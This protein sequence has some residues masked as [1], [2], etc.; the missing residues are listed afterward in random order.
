MAMPAKPLPRKLDV[1]RLEFT[2]L[3][4]E[5]WKDFAKL[6]GSNGACGGCWCMAWRLARAEFNAG[7]GEPNRKAMRK[8]VDSG[9]MPG[10]L[11]YYEGEPIGWC[12]I[13]PREVYPALE[14]S[15]VL[16]PI[17]ERPVWSVSCFFVAKPFRVQGVSVELLKA[18]VRFAASRG[19]T[20]VEGYPQDLGG[21]KLPAPFVWTGLAG[22]F[23]AAGFQEAARR[24]RTRP[25][26]RE[27]VTS[28]P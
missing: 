21:S 28:R 4:K 26:M 19:A 23:R 14:R 16:K 6:F 8:I 3:T 12:A 25:I 18:A 7:K 5:R 24:S 20:L 13:A 9:A 10:V 17:D 11:A 1:A 22:A 27:T 2:P 15:R